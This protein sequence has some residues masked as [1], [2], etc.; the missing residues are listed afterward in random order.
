MEL[1]LLI[2][3]CIHKSYIVYLEIYVVLI[4]HW[5]FHDQKMKIHVEKQGHPVFSRRYY[6]WYSFS[7]LTLLVGWHKAH[8]ACKKSGVGL[9]ALGDW[10]PV[11]DHSRVGWT[12]RWDG[13]FHINFV[14][15]WDWTQDLKVAVQSTNHCTTVLQNCYMCEF[16]PWISLKVHYLNTV[17]FGIFQPWKVVKTVL[18]CLHEPCFI[19][20]FSFC[21]RCQLMLQAVATQ[22]EAIQR[23]L[24]MERECLGAAAPPG[25]PPMMRWVRKP[26]R[27]Y[28]VDD[29]IDLR[30]RL[31][32]PCYSRKRWQAAL[33]SSHFRMIFM[34]VRSVVLAL[35]ALTPLVRWQERHVS[36]KKT[37]YWYADGD[38]LT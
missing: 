29:C 15:V 21:R 37:A 31:V 5:F 12:R 2:L 36:H 28:C 18:K 10:L 9:L 8:P 30:H 13:I 17:E 16:A 7:A 20:F 33:Q 23:H 11:T 4:G 1:S 38:G 32:C 3:A 27:S 34:R 25:G 24:A 19:V 6:L 14:L 22:Q 35:G 26:S